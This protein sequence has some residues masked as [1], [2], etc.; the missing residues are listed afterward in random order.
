MSRTSKEAPPE[1]QHEHHGVMQL[2]QRGNLRRLLSQDTVP[3]QALSSAAT[4]TSWYARLFLVV[5][6]DACGLRRSGVA[7]L[8]KACVMDRRKSSSTGVATFVAQFA[9]GRMKVDLR[10]LAHSS[11]PPV[12]ASPAVAGSPRRGIWQKS[13]RWEAMRPSSPRP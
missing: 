6:C 12:G 1:A 11:N 9:H 3:Y 10:M 5:C 7:A 4:D 8:L 2:S 13:K